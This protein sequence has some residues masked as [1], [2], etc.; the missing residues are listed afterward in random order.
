MKKKLLLCLIASCMILLS[1]G[2][3]SADNYGEVKAAYEKYIQSYDEFKKAAESGADEETL[4]SHVEKYQAAHT[5]YSGMLKKY[6]VGQNDEKKIIQEVTGSSVPAPDSMSEETKAFQARAPRISETPSDVFTQAMEAL[7]SKDKKDVPAACEKLKKIAATSKKADEVAQAKLILARA[8]L[9]YYKDLVS[10][11]KLLSEVAASKPGK[12]QTE[13]VKRLSAKVAEEKFRAKSDAVVAK[14]QKELGQKQGEF[15][16]TPGGAPVPAAKI[17]KLAEYAQSCSNYNDSLNKLVKEQ[18]K[19]ELSKESIEKNIAESESKKPAVIEEHMF[20]VAKEAAAAP[21]KP[22][23]RVISSGRKD[24]KYISITFDDGPHGKLTPQLLAILETNEVKA[25]FFAL[26]QGINSNPAV[27]K[28]EMEKGHVIGNHS[29]THPCYTKLSN[30]AI[31]KELDS[32]N[33]A[34][35]KACGD[36]KIRYYRPPYGALPQRLKNRAASEDFYIILWSVDSL[37]WKRYAP[38][39]TMA[40]VMK[41]MHNGA[42]LLFHDIHPT[43]IELMKKLLPKL[44]GQGYKFVSLDELLG[45]KQIK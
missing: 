17:Q 23:K 32:G 13:E 26:G 24:G 30:A 44:K 25:T 14:G 39:V 36:V 6:N 15:V 43:T 40:T 29:F 28:R 9:E 7:D 2:P 10:A 37:D 45:F 12:S 5:E 42:I 4:K 21:A 22:A 27:V 34:I 19:S 35:K 18:P 33:A 20:P 1:G 41:E 31:D 16:K 11:E 38:D 8:S 3:S